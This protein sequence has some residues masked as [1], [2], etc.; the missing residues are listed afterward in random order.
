MRPP[1]GL[2][3]AGAIYR[4][5]FDGA[6]AQIPAKEAVGSKAHNLMQLAGRGLPVPP[7][8][9]LGTEVCRDYLRR[10][11]VALEGLAEVLDRELHQ[12]ALRTGRHFGDVKR[13]LLV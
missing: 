9:V 10:G 13:P 11:E 5:P 1:A 3:L 4:I 2:S 6:A 7:A 12:L 8:F